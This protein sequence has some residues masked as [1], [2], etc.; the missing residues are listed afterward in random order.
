M[1]IIGS[2]LIA[3]AFQELDF[4]KHLTCFASGVSNS[5]EHRQSEFARESDLLKYWL[6]RS[7]RLLYFSTCSVQDKSLKNSLY[8]IH[9][10]EMEALVLS[11]SEN[12]IV[13]LPQV[14]GECKNKHTLTNFIA[15]KIYNKERYDLYHGAL[16]N[17]ID[18]SDVVELT[19]YLFNSDYRRNL[20]SFAMPVHHEVSE[21]VEIFQ[22]LL[23]QTSL[24]RS[25]K[26]VPV[27]YP[28]SDFVKIAIDNK[29]I[30]YGPDYLEKV[31]R[32]YYSDYPNA[33]S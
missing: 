31:L 14:V 12:I 2:G 8:I 23:N 3:S 1:N 22:A 21:L 28:E 10:K 4:G 5:Q 18:V 20:Y 7:R 29:V 30:S 32:K 11:K 26:G 17:L 27:K 6:D 33:I 24:H 19:K 16:R 15:S 9:K 13:R 25:V